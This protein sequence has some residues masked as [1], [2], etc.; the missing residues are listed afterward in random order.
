MRK[1]FSS[2]KGRNFAKN[3]RERRANPKGLSPGVN[4][5]LTKQHKNNVGHH[6]WAPKRGRDTPT[7]TAIGAN[8]GS[9]TVAAFQHGRLSQGGRV[10]SPDRSRGT[11]QFSRSSWVSCMAVCPAPA[12]ARAAFTS[13]VPSGLTSRALAWGAAL[14]GCC[15][16]RVEM[17]ICEGARHLF[18]RSLNSARGR[19]GYHARGRTWAHARLKNMRP[20]HLGYP[21]RAGALAWHVDA[22]NGR[23]F[24]VRR[25]ERERDYSGNSTATHQPL[26]CWM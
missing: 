19:R 22:P 10:P 11:A 21:G 12:P 9:I 16:S 6:M 3:F 5:P 4:G 24:F 15:P 1:K 17:R 26:T 18:W 14:G 23:S 13:N 8:L 7:A 2:K 25:C 20:A